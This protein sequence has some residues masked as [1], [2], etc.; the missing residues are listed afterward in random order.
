MISFVIITYNSEKYIKQC[1]DHI[2]AIK[3]IPYEIIVVDNDSKDDT[4]RIVKDE[5]E[6]VKLIELDRNVG[7]A[8][9]V[10]I[11][12]RNAAKD[13]IFLLNPDAYIKIA[14]LP[15][16][17]EYLSS[18]HVGP[19]GPKVINPHDSN[20]QYSARSFPTLKTGIFNRSSIFTSLIPN[21]R[22]S[23]GYLNPLVSDDLRQPVDW[24]SGCAMIFRKEV[25]D[26]VGGFDEAFFVFYEDIDFCYRLDQAGYRAAYSPSVVVSHEIGIS[27]TVP[28]IK[29][30]YERHR[31]MWVYYAKHFKRNPFT[32]VIIFFGISLR[33]AITSVK[34]LFRN[35]LAIFGYSRS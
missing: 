20:R 16:C 28:T 7:F 21:N 23:M 32:A 17:I 27:R 19:V 14:D 11:G 35:F 25:F 3:D 30:N 1:L 34:V 15:D 22:Y 5:F 2:L 31:G 24:V 6:S 9:G 13:V 8:S 4:K 18:D 33:F 12:V 26:L 29:I 10:N